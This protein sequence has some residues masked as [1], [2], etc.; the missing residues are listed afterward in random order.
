M[1]Y[2]LILLFVGYSWG[3]FP[4]DPNLVWGYAIGI[5]QS[6]VGATPRTHADSITTPGVWARNWQTGIPE[7]AR[8][9]IA[10]NS[11]R[12]HDADKIHNINIWGTSFAYSFAKTH[13]SKCP[14][15]VEILLIPL[16]VGGTAISEWQKGQPNYDTMANVM[17]ACKSICT[18][19]GVIGIQGESDAYNTGLSS[20]WQSKVA[21][22]MDS[23]R[24]DLSTPMLTLVLG[25]ISDSS[26]I[27][28]F[29]CRDSII[30]Y[31]DGITEKIK[32]SNIV[33][34][35][36]LHIYDGVHYDTTAQR[37]IGQMFDAAQTR[38]ENVMWVEP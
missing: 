24:K 38:L 4:S 18:L 30:K 31:T 22:C 5:C 34:C 36:N 6:N 11:P 13:L 26:S 21:S 32:Y 7:L 2:I 9:P 19:K 27:T 33:F 15:G 1:K 14:P 29:P 3:A 12:E 23:L 37:A 16:S 35:K 8:D 28:T 20:A 10:L 25:E 17:K